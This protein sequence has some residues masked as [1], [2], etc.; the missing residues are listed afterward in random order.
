[1]DK[2]FKAIC[3]VCDNSLNREDSPE[4]KWKNRPEYP[5]DIQILK[6]KGDNILGFFPTPC[7][8]YFFVTNLAHDQVTVVGEEDDGIMDKAT[9]RYFKIDRYGGDKK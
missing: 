8:G 7:H 4:D 3:D 1:M 6:T 9:L 5:S 2:L